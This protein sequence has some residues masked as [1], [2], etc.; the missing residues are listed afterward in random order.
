MH[1]YLKAEDFLGQPL[2]SQ[3][4]ISASNVCCQ[5]LMFERAFLCTLKLGESSQVGQRWVV[6][7]ASAPSSGTGG[8]RGVQH[9]PC[10]SAGDMESASPERDISNTSQNPSAPCSLLHKL[11]FFP[12]MHYSCTNRIAGL[13]L[14]GPF[15]VCTKQDRAGFHL[16][17]PA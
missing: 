3:A 5:D 10:R 8:N 12:A 16:V 13:L 6:V 17:R 7:C 1:G 9:R 14:N 4:H 11:Q 2:S 15:A